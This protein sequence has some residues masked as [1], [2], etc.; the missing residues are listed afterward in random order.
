[1]NYEKNRQVIE[2]DVTWV[3]WRKRIVLNKI[4]RALF[5]LAEDE[6]AEIK[7]LTIREVKR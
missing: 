6:K 4:L 1:M 3:G 5:V 2:I 7:R